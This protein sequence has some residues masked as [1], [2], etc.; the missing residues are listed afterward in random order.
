MEKKK[1][2]LALSGGIA[3][4]LA[5]IG[6]LEV[7]E[8]ERIP[9]DMIAGTSAGAVVGAS[10]AQKKDLSMVRKFARNLTHKRFVSLI[11]ITL[12]KNGL[13]QGN[14]INRLLET[15][16]SR[17]VRFSDLE[18]PFACTT[19]DIM[20]GEEVVLNQ[21]LLLES[22][23]ASISIPVIFAIAKLHGRYLVD[24]QLVNPVPVSTLKE[25][26]ADFIIAV[27]VIPN[28]K[29][30]TRQKEK[31]KA[32]S[33]LDAIMNSLYI[34]N[35]LLIEHSLERA[36]IIIEPDVVHISPSDIHK[37]E[38]CISLGK[39]AAEESILKIRNQLEA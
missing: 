29:A 11:D 25:M 6:V 24:G 19:T 13:I 1:V 15:I 20:T 10:Y 3:R 36:D 9:I 14:K 37:A 30:E 38:E 28:F 33:I 34:T 26:G 23:R 2:G 5:H 17:Q 7:L 22:V 35:T 18:I 39:K 12:P 32:P 4:G 21:G 31:L 8:K 16:I 27:N